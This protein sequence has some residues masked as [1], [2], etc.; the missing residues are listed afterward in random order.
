MAS[1]TTN[2]NRKSYDVYLSLCDED[3][4]PFVLRLYTALSSEDGIV[5]F[6]DNE[7]LGSEL[8]KITE[9][10]RTSDLIVLPVFYDGVYPSNGSLK[11]SMFGEAFHDLVKRKTSSWIGWQGSVKVTNIQDQ[12]IS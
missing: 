8:E 1:F 6:W 5:V 12:D 3:A 4:G 7:R 11:S 10:C 2:P 9:F